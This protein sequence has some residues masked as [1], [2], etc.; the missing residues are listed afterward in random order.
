M[1]MSLLK[2]KPNLLPERAGWPPVQGWWSPDYR[3]RNNTREMTAP[4][5]VLVP[6]LKPIFRLL[7]M[8]NVPTLH[9]N[10]L[11]GWLFKGSINNLLSPPRG[12][13]SPS[14]L[15]TDTTPMPLWPLALVSCEQTAQEG[16]EIALKRLHYPVH[17][18]LRS[19]GSPCP[20]P[21]SRALDKGDQTSLPPLRGQDSLQ[22]HTKPFFSNLKTK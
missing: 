18:H 2:Q 17:G 16:K 11:F 19:Q 7:S 21:E 8:E 4:S 1:Q 12:I 3:G 5:W 22:H 13:C 15:V 6:T 10:K 9:T 20:G 14:S